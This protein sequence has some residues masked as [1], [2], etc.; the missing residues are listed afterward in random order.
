MPG[1]VHMLPLI[2]NCLVVF[3]P[4]TFN[5]L[6]L[7]DEVQ[8]AFMPGRVHMLVL[9]DEVHA[10]LCQEQFTCCRCGRSPGFFMSGTVLMLPL[11]DEVQVLFMSGSVDMLHCWMKY[12]LSLCH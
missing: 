1:R 7:V 11:E 8:V 10:S 12:R 4:E 3:M 5:L 9:E 2:G 6:L